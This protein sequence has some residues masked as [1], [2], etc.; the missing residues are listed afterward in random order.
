MAT[1]TVSVKPH[2]ELKEDEHA[3]ARS[4][5]VVHYQ[6]IIDQDE[7]GDITSREASL[8][9]DI[10]PEFAGQTEIIKYVPGAP[11][12]LSLTSSTGM[13]ILS[14]NVEGGQLDDG[15]HVWK[16][17]KKEIEK[18][19]E[20]I[21]RKPLYPSILNRQGQFISIG[22]PSP[23]FSKY[24]LM[25]SP[26]RETEINPE[27]LT[28]LFNVESFGT[29]SKRL[30]NDNLTELVKLPLGELVSTK[31]GINGQFQFSV[32]VD[33]NEAG[34]VWLL[35]GPIVFIGIQ[36]ESEQEEDSLYLTATR[37]SILL[38]PP[39]LDDPDEEAIASEII[40][41]GSN[42]GTSSNGDRHSLDV[43]EDELLNN[44]DVFNDAPGAFCRPFSNPN[45]VVSERSFHT[46][47]RV[48]QPTVGSRPYVPPYITPRLPLGAFPDT[49]VA[50]DTSTTGG[51]GRSVA[52]IR[53][54]IGVSSLRESI[55][56]SNF[57][58]S[59][60]AASTG[61]REVSSVEMYADE[62]KSQLKSF[63]RK[64]P[65][66]R[67]VLNANTPLNWEGDST[68]YQST[69]LGFGHVLESRVQWRNNGYSL[70]RVAHSLTLAPR[71]TKR[72]VTI[73]S[74]IADKI[75]R[76][77]AT[78]FSESVDTGTD[79]EYSYQDQ[80]ESHL[81]EWSKGGSIS[82]AMGS[83]S[84]IGGFISGVLFGGGSAFGLSGSASA[85]RGGRD[86][87]SQENQNL[88]DSIRTYG[89]SLRQLD[90]MVVIDQSQEEFVQGVSETVRNINYTH[91]LTIIYHEI[92][93]HLRVDT[94]IVGARECV[95]VPFEIKSFDLTR[96]L[97]WRDTLSRVLRKHRLRWVMRYLPDAIDKFVG[98]TIPNEI[99]SKIPIKHVTGSVYIQLKIE[100][101]NDDADGTY[102]KDNW[103]S[104]LP[105]AF[106]PVLGIF[107]FISALAADKKDDAF[108][109]KYAPGIAT[110]WA[111]KLS[112]FREVNQEITGVDFTLA[113]SYHYGRTVRVD[114]SF[115]QDS[116]E[117]NRGHLVKLAVKSPD[118]PEGSIANVKQIRVHYYTDHFDYQV[119]SPQGTDDLLDVEGKSA[120]E[121]ASVHLPTNRWEEV[122]LQDE[123][124]KAADEL[125]DHLDEYTEYYHK[126][127]W[128]SLDRDKLFMMLDGIKL[129]PEDERSVA[130]VVERNPMAVVGNSLVYR[131]ATGAFI[132]VDGHQDGDSLNYHYRDKN[133]QAEPLRISLP[134]SGLYAQSL[135]DE[136]EACEEHFG[137]TDWVLT[138]DEPE[139]A[140][141]GPELLASRRA[142]SPDAT[143]T[144]FPDSIINI[145]NAAT[146][147]PPSGFADTLNAVTNA[148][149]FRDMA[150]LAGT[151]ANAR[152]A[153]ESAAGLAAKFGSEA[154]ALY[155][156]QMSASNA[157]NKMSTIKKAHNE[158]S[159]DDEEKKRQTMKVLEEMNS[160]ENQ[161]KGLQELSEFLESQEEQPSSLRFSDRDG[162]KTL[163]VNNPSSPE[164]DAVD[165]IFGPII[166]IPDL[167]W[168]SSA[169]D[170]PNELTSGFIK[171]I[172]GIDF[173]INFLIDDIAI[174]EYISSLEVHMNDE[175]EGVIAQTVIAISTLNA[176]SVLDILKLDKINA[177]K[178]NNLPQNMRPMATRT[179]VLLAW[180]DRAISNQ[181]IVDIDNYKME[182]KKQL[183]FYK[184]MKT[185]IESITQFIPF[186]GPIIGE[187]IAEILATGINTVVDE[188][189]PE[190]E[191][192]GSL[193]IFKKSKT[194]KKFYK[195][196]QRT[197]FGETLD[198]VI[199]E[200]GIVPSGAF[201]GVKGRYADFVIGAWDRE[202]QRL[203]KL[204]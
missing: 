102:I 58:E 131:V 93:R 177:F 154:A 185:V 187:R 77:E 115:T 113:S 72:I 10:S 13:L 41:G 19:K 21:D 167:K 42:P 138:N 192:D 168:P 163:L 130:S 43:S 203:P 179:G 137:S 35:N 90:S 174:G 53:E 31:I 191:Q 146:P 80:V 150:G 145:Q 182:Y 86:V 95:F 4:R 127:I 89:D 147:P 139:L 132:G 194:M 198:V 36:K 38:P 141:L 79:R 26:I 49:T 119:S 22:F 46:I 197:I 5:V 156:A 9:F 105:F 169:I 57:R 20:N 33:G 152:A 8:S 148:N 29:V 97:K 94:R 100:R 54:S 180:V 83:A 162:G 104:L 64:V 110:N 81:K 74:K 66:G 158:G 172:N 28:N 1:L 166:N 88:R 118:L 65:R 108:Q 170:E 159:I 193:K 186:A 157:K 98:S 78:D 59:L 71:Q 153:M 176:I 73:Q 7:N 144:E 202:Q 40:I 181:T 23:D 24:K 155:K 121:L 190:L 32:P 25:I 106:V 16:L 56:V 116:S 189:I 188:F 126:K 37:R 12:N 161:S 44:P 69:S 92:L 143:P 136:C 164:S 76:K 84:G 124:R 140:E 171:L 204:T 96:I 2:T 134:T 18:V 62:Y 165:D 114:F 200:G 60:V 133:T 27:T 201:N 109:K 103:K 117:L 160:T 45:R 34:W 183:Q 123:I 184:S 112:L 75:K 14:E 68:E 55:G 17:N 199:F 128:W 178:P 82:A 47:L 129:S 173:G 111:D 142:P 175:L 85:Q 48:E 195:N 99:R 3:K 125:T 101:P 63:A 91:S 151:Q 196:L 149:A 67:F 61:A 15:E 11:I 135:M 6:E 51:R 52:N 122:N 39:S 50:R 107:S 120:Q 30:R 70:G 87:A